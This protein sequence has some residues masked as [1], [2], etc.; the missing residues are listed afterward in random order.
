MRRLLA[1]LALLALPPLAQASVPK[2]A[3]IIQE[4]GDTDPNTS[5]AIL[6]RLGV[7]FDEYKV[8]TRTW[9]ATGTDDSVW[10]RQRYS[11][12][13]I[14]FEA[15]GSG[16]SH[17]TLLGWSTNFQN[18]AATAALIH[19]PLSGRWGIPV[20]VQHNRVFPSTN[21]D[22]LA[23]N[24]YVSGI[25]HT[26]PAGTVLAKSADTLGTW[27]KR[28]MYRWKDG[29]SPDTLYAEPGPATSYAYGCRAAPTNGTVAALAWT[30]TVASTCGGIDTLMTFWRYRPT[31]TGPG[32]YHSMY[33]NKPLGTVMILQHLFSVTNVRP[34]ARIL[35]PITEHDPHAAE[36]AGN[37]V[38]N[39]TT[40]RLYQSLER[41][42]INRYVGVVCQATE[43]PL[44]DATTLNLVRDHTKRGLARWHPFTY[45]AG[46]TLQFY[47]AADTA[48]VRSRWNSTV[49]TAT[50][51]DSF[52]LRTASYLPARI[53]SSGGVV[54][55]WAGKPLADAGVKIVETTLTTPNAGGWAYQAGPANMPQ[56]V[57]HSIPGAGETRVMYSQFTSALPHDSSFTSLSSNPVHDFIVMTWM[58]PLGD[59]AKNRVSLYWHTG[60]AVGVSH[61][62]PYYSWLID[63]LGDHFRYF[64]KVIAPDN[65]FANQILTVRNSFNARF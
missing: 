39:A 42:R 28:T 11:A 47:T 27:R 17:P 25:N 22:D 13:Y 8:E 51:A 49:N 64:D 10:F 34:A 19:G 30:D 26:Q 21:Y 2:I 53:V 60:G 41:N 32:I 4:G 3:L 45:A 14:P 20:F 65:G 36:A 63:I 15:G 62:D 38:Y 12:V 43:Y 57:P 61:V 40:T 16:G 6:R 33:R 23:G 18:A 59:A 24:F 1:V 37:S 29:R 46:W 52:A 9:G 56:M 58:A 55:A 44:Y 48:G 50:R 7:P 54:G 35:I 31:S 5:R